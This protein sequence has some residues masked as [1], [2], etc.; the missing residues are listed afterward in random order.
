MCKVGY[1]DF[2]FDTKI[3]DKALGV[4]KENKAK[5]LKK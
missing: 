5:I 4:T 2:G 1:N 3:L